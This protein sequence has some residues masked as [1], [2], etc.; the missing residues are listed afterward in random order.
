M[1]EDKNAV[2]NQVFNYSRIKKRNMTGTAD[3]YGI[4]YGGVDTR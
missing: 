2:E 1:I 4:R 3:K